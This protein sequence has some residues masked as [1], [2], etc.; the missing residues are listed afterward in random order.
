MEFDNLAA[1]QGKVVTSI[2]RRDDPDE[3]FFTCADGSEF[4]MYHYQECC[5]SVGIHE[6]VGDE[7]DLLNTPILQ[8]SERTNRENEDINESSTWTFYR[9]STIK[10]T[11]VISWYGSSNGYYSEA[12]NFDQVK[13]E[14]GKPYLQ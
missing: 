6:I 4:K 3:I 8:A 9:I 12:V 14:G 10:G 13:T 7:E 5:E 1:L 11:V 2:S